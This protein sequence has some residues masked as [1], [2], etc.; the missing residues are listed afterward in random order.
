MRSLVIGFKS[1]HVSIMATVLNLFSNDQWEALKASPL[2]E[3][4]KV[5]PPVNDPCV[6]CALRDICD[7]E[8]CAALGFPIDSP[9]P[10][11]LFP[12]LGVYIDYLKKQGWR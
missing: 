5:C 2:E 8:D 10:S 7:N 1:Y 12:N 6:K 3:V 4:V 11:T 9:V